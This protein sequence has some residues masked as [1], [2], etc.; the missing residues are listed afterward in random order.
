MFVVAN[1]TDTGILTFIMIS[2][3]E[4]IFV[5]PLLLFNIYSLFVY[6]Y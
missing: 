5:T 1:E 4:N 6:H 3:T 2:N